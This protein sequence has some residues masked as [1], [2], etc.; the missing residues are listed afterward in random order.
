MKIRRGEIF[1]QPVRLVTKDK[2]FMQF[3]LREK[4]Q[5]IPVLAGVDSEC[6][7]V[8]S[9]VHERLGMRFTVYPHRGE[10]PQR[11]VGSPKGSQ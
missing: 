3:S 2:E 10:V 5:I 1:P 8:L 7:E 11:P 9:V 6:V 4:T